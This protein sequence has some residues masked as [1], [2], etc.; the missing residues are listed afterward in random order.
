[1]QPLN[2]VRKPWPRASSSKKQSVGVHPVPWTTGGPLSRRRRGRGDGQGIVVATADGIARGVD[3]AP[4]TPAAPVAAVA[5]DDDDDEP[6]PPCGTST[7]I[8]VD[9]ARYESGLLFTPA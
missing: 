8:I 4:P 7:H 3:S 2:G 1:M 6:P 9:R 5:T